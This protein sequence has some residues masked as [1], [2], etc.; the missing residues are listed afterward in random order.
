MQAETT[1]KRRYRLLFTVQE[2]ITYY[3][4]YQAVNNSNRY[5]GADIGGVA[6]NPDAA[7]S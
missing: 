6:E 1:E 4:I 5:G 2:C 7:M 3:L